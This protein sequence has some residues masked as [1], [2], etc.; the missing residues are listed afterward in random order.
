M[1]EPEKQKGFFMDCNDIFK[2]FTA[3]LI[4]AEEGW[5]L[6]TQT[7]SPEPGIG[8]I[9]VRL[10]AEQA[11]TPPKTE[12]AWSVPQQDIQIRWTPVSGFQKSVPPDWGSGIAANLAESAPVV[13]FLNLNGQNRMTVAVEEA[14]R[15]VILSAGYSEEENTVVVKVTLFSQPESPFAEYET[16]IRLDLRACFYAKSIGDASAWFA[17][18]EKYQPAVVPETAFDAIY[19]TWYS[20]HQNLFDHELEAEC[21]LAAQAGLN[22]VIVDDGWQTDDNNRGYAFCGDWEVTQKR[23]PDMKAHVAKIHALGM[24]YML[25]YSVPFM[26]YESKNYSR[27]AGKFLFNIDG[28][29]TSVLDPRFPEVREFLINTYETA[30]K[31]WDLDGFKLDF[32]DS[33]RFRGADPAIAENY[34]GRDILSLPLAVDRLL[35]DV[36]ARLRKLKPEIL[37]EFRQSYIGPAIR[38][39]G[40]MFRAGDCPADILLNRVRTLDLRLLSGNTAVHSDMLEW[41]MSTPVESAAL[42]ILNILFSVP[43]ISIRFADLPDDHRKM[44]RFWLDFARDNKDI[45]LKGDL[46]PLHPELNYPIVY[47][48]NGE[49]QVAAVYG[50]G[51]IVRINPEQKTCFVINAS[52]E[53]GLILDLAETPA[54]CSMFETTGEKVAS[55]ALQKGLNRVDIPA[56]G[57]LEIHF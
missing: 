23:F 33:F 7:E 2:I 34:E 10:T 9:K 55:P 15:P 26:G 13:T 22:G 36:M 25:W 5:K 29:K 27:F 4:S 32:I 57:L 41:N 6:E 14:M 11:Q 20:Y 17:A 43:Q 12:I 51:Q 47:A 54:A 50:A 38:K 48:R 44:V 39:Y 35:S 42:Q 31:E 1:A 28:L 24:K 30:I 56:S 8:L 18:M 40:N 19:S 46:I 45:L 3:K 52:G 16:V 21:V 37:I 53:A 49:K